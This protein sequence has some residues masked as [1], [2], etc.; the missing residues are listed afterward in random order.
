MNYVRDN[1]IIFS[2]EFIDKDICNINVEL[3]KILNGE[4]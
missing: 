3:R 4:V 1:S 2:G